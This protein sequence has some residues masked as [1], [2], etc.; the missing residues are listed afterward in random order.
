MEA[1]YQLDITR[2]TCPITFVRTKLQIE[3]MAVGELLRVR[4]RGREPL[5]N[6]PRSAREE[7]HEIV[8][9][10]REDAISDVH[11]VMIRKGPAKA[12]RDA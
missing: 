1:Q 9:I 10:E 7:G 5:E 11:C 3:K 12:D 8:A 6:V 2:D 4:L